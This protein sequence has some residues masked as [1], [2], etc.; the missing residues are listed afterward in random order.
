VPHSWR[1]QCE[2]AYRMCMRVLIVQNS[3]LAEKLSLQ[4]NL[5]QSLCRYSAT[6]FEL[7]GDFVARPLPELRP[8]TSLSQPPLLDT[9]L[10][11]CIDIN[12]VYWRIGFCV[13][14]I[15]RVWC[16][17]FAAVFFRPEIIDDCYYFYYPTLLWL[18]GQWRV[19]LCSLY[20]CP[21][22]L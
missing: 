4:L 3:R 18:A 21:L 15:L 19:M 16:F 13:N 11:P 14:M 17:M 10:R 20:L 7:L 12:L 6:I 8:R 5:R 22:D 1:R 2:L 9:E